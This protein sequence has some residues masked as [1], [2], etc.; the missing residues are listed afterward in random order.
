MDVLVDFE[1][2][3][4]EHP[5]D[6]VRSKAFRCETQ[7]LRL[8]EFSPGFADAEWCSN[9]HA[10]HVLEGALTLEMKH[11]DTMVLHQG[12]VAFLSA[13]DDHAHRAS[14]DGESP[15]RLLLFEVV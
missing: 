3:P 14:V 4:W 1:S 7:Q 10:V 8:I 5:A 11:G 15:A 13:G 2:M 9:G 12:D 6:G